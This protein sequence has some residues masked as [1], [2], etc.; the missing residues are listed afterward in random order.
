[1]FKFVLFI[2]IL[3]SIGTIILAQDNVVNALKREQNRNFKKD[4]DTTTNWN[5]K[6]GGMMSF[7]LAQGSLSNWAAGGDN[8]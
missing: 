5:W 8:F 2:T 7:N 1:M 6:R 4:N 3:L